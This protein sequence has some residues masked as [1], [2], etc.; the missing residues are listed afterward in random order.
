MK[1][2]LFNVVMLFFIDCY[3]QIPEIVRQQC[4]PDPLVNSNYQT[5]AQTENGYILG[6]GINNGNN[7]SNYHGSA[8][9]WII[10]TDSSFNT[11]WERCYGGSDTDNPNEIVK[12]TESEY[13]IFG[14]TSS[15]DGDVQSGNNGFNDIWVV[16]INIQGE[17]IW[18]NTYGCP[19]YDEIRDFI[20]TPDGGFVMIDRIGSAGGDVS[21]YYG[22]GDVWMCKCDSLGNIEWEKT[23]G[24]QGLDNCISLTINNEGNIMMIGAVQQHGG[25]VE[26]YPDGVWGDVW[27]VELDLQGDIISQ[28]CYGGS[29]Y[30]LGFSIIELEDGYIFAADTHSD[31]GDVSGLHGSPGGGSDIWVVRLNEQFGIIWQKCI[32]GYDN[33]LPVYITQTTDNGFFIIGNTY[34]NDGDVSGNHSIS[35]YD[36]DIWAVKLDSLGE[37]EW[38][39]CYGGLG[40]ETAGTWCAS[41]VL[42]IN[43]YNYILA[44]NTD[45]GPS[46][47]VQC[48]AEHTDAWFFELKDCAYYA[49]ATPATPCGAD[50][51]CSAGG[52]ATVYT[53]T[54]AQ[55]WSYAWQLLPETAGTISG[56]STIATVS[57]AENYEGTAVITVRSQNDC[58]QSNWSEPKYTQV[59]TCLGTEEIPEE[60]T[61]LRVYPNPAKDYVIFEFDVQ[62]LMFEVKRKTEIKIYDA[63]GREVSCLPVMQKKTI[64]LTKNMRNGLYYYKTEINGKALSG[65]VVI[66]D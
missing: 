46:Y 65:K 16:K 38:Q 21:Q 43:D 41:T 31:D 48:T 24:N 62:S 66:R 29:D 27:L 34:S 33:E 53:V 57:W 61:A 44:A 8:D 54:P 51:A 17:I 56:D 15:T 42:K 11:I 58:G 55:A 5:I 6:V 4:Y 50:T 36:T 60:T 26:C 25:M 64:W 63:F 3:A 20:L 28:H 35:E 32:G 2:I 40:S 30:D 1:I 23:L 22:N 9:I 14:S 37:I 12:I 59:F 13:Y 18:E 49:P 7:A 19:G 47:D 45:Y 10:V 39:R 52:T